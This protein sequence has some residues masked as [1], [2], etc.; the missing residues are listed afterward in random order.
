MDTGSFRTS[1]E[2]PMGPCYR[3]VEVPQGFE[4]DSKSPPGAASPVDWFPPAVGVTSLSPDQSWE[5]EWG[6]VSCPG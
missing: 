4:T 3:T 6:S 1:G 2:P 5:W